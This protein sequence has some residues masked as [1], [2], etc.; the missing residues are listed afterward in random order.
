[1][2]SLYFALP[3]T[4]QH[5]VPPNRPQI[6]RPLNILARVPFNQHKISL[7]ALFDRTSI[8]KP[9]ALRCQTSRGPQ[10]LERREPAFV[11]KEEE[12]MMKRETPRSSDGWRRG[13]RATDYQTS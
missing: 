9:K 13:V 8:V 3:L 11:D 6:Q 7:Q 2:G 10:S 4:S 1:M 12:F 5:P